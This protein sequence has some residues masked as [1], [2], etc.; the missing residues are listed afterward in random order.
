MVMTFPNEYMIAVK[1]N[2][3]EKDGND[4]QKKRELSTIEMITTAYKS[5]LLKLKRQ[6][7]PMK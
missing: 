4:E 6:S 5:I 3:R 7:A 1:E 2:K